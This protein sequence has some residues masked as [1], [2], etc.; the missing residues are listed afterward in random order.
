V[1]SFNGTCASWVLSARALASW[2]D[3]F[4]IHP[5]CQQQGRQ[6]ARTPRAL[7]SACDLRAV[8]CLRLQRLHGLWHAHAVGGRLRTSSRMAASGRLRN[9]E[10]NCPTGL[11]QVVVPG[12][13][14]HTATAA[15]K[16]PSVLCCL[17][18]ILHPFQENSSAYIVRTRAVVRAA[19]RSHLR[20]SAGSR[21][22]FSGQRVTYVTDQYG[23]YS[24]CSLMAHALQPK[25]TSPCSAI[26]C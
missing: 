25:L 9:G 17:S 2:P 13:H 26:S 10:C 14:E 4:W 8:P 5:G 24:S 11:D 22:V 7:Q 15:I 23:T 12:A 16:R 19:S 21:A 3:P 20:R 18:I 1:I 6:Q